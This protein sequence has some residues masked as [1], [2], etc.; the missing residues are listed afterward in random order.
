ME[1]NWADYGIAWLEEEV[2]KRTDG[3]T[4]V[5]ING[6][7][8]IP[9]VIDVQKALD[10]FGNEAIA[11]ALNG[12]SWRV[13]AQDVNRRMLPGKPSVDVLRQAVYNRLLGIRNAASVVTKTVKVYTL[14]N[15][16]SYTGSDLLE[17]Q[18]AFIAAM[19]DLGIDSATAISKSQALAL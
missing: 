2:A 16:T 12:T 9:Q 19:V 3:N 11:G 14:P 13:A 5:I 7:A 10:H 15:G 8:Q 17:Y 6:A 18:Q 1:Q 4:K